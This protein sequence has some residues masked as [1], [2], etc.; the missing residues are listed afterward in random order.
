MDN[1]LFVRLLEVA[2]REV[3]VNPHNQLTASGHLL[4][5]LLGIVIGNYE[6]TQP[7]PKRWEPLDEPIAETAT[8]SA[9]PAI[10]RRPPTE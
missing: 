3:W 1:E 5:Q 7:W 6:E 9:E 8:T 2:P 4:G 10:T